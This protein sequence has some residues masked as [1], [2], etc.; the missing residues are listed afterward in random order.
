MDRS[1]FSG[2]Y[3]TGRDVYVERDLPGKANPWLS[4]RRRIAKA[5]KVLSA[6]AKDGFT[7]ARTTNFDPRLNVFT[8]EECESKDKTQKKWTRAGA[9]TRFYTSI[10]EIL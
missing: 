3:K 7:A 5:Q 2:A 10:R 6:A 9:A 1:L 4:K 8:V